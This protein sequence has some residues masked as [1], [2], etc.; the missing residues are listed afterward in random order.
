MVIA[1]PKEEI[2]GRIL[3][4]W[5]PTKERTR[6]ER[7]SIDEN[8]ILC[9]K[10]PGLNGFYHAGAFSILEF[11]KI[12]GNTCPT[13]TFDDRVKI[14]PALKLTEFRKRQVDHGGY[15]NG[16]KEVIGVKVTF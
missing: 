14:D 8:M 10:E 13:F 12:N 5:L 15:I 2:L 3:V 1:A 7:S 16:M 6:H 4:E 9:L 11:P